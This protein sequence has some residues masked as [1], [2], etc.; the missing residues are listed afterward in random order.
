V[1]KEPVAGAPPVPTT[2]QVE[3]L[4]R[5]ARAWGTVKYLHPYLA[6]KAIDWDKAAVDAIPRVLAAKQDDEY[7]AAVQTMLDVLGDPAPGWCTGCPPK[8]RCSRERAGS[9]AGSFSFLQPIAA[10]A[11]PKYRGRTVTLIDERAI[12]QAEHTGLFLEAACGTTFIGSPTQGANGHV[13]N[14]VLP[15]NLTVTFTGHDAR[16]ADGRQLQ[17]VGLV[18][19]SEVR[20]TIKG[21][22]DRKD[23][24]LERAIKHLNEVICRPEP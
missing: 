3:R 4:D 23:E 2:E 6:Y 18:P 21:F 8:P 15:G 12:G 24:V 16:H 13:P 1:K 11:K 9:Q 17:R 22:R 19:Q 7:T 14:F 10:T 5:L 20:P